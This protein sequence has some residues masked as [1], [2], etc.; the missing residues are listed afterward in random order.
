MAFMDNWLCKKA[1]LSVNHGAG[2][3]PPNICMGEPTTERT[4]PIF[5]TV[6]ACK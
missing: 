2:L 4:H 3:P 1:K 6:G 5:S